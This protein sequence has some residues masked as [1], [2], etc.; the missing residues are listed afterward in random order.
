MIALGPKERGRNLVQYLFRC[1][2]SLCV[3]QRESGL[4][5]DSSD[6]SSDGSSDDSGEEE[7]EVVVEEEAM[8]L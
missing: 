3:E 8:K 4:F 5:D 6:D 1:E 2:C 7:E